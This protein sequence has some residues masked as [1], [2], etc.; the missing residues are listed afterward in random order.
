M[1]YCFPFLGCAIVSW[2]S[3]PLRSFF[4]PVTD[5]WCVKPTSDFCFLQAALILI[6]SGNLYA[7]QKNKNTF[8][9]NNCSMFWVGCVSANKT[10][11]LGGHGSG[12][13]TPWVKKLSPVPMRI[14]ISKAAYFAAFYHPAKMGGWT[15]VQESSHTRRSSA[16]KDP[17]SRTTRNTRESRQVQDRT[18]INPPESL[19]NRFLRPQTAQ[20]TGIRTLFLLIVAGENLPFWSDK[21][22]PVFHQL[23]FHFFCRKTIPTCAKLS[24]IWRHVRGVKL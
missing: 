6:F 21:I 1:P 15:K 20:E 5:L 10:L 9:F 22:F 11:N 7:K 19:P 18:C 17:I 14:T 4:P 3:A 12:S 24:S 13:G 16:S 2:S 8:T 23:F